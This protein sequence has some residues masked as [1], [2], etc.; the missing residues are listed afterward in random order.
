MVF[1]MTLIT[2][3]SDQILIFAKQISKGKDQYNGF[4]LLFMIQYQELIDCI[5]HVVESF[6]FGC[7]DLLQPVT[8]QICILVYA[9]DI[10]LYIDLYV[11]EI[12]IK[13]NKDPVSDKT[14]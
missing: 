10:C 14:T 13:H 12:N 1:S 5:P 4:H 11:H 3:L 7:F 9:I 8:L 2:Q 6:S